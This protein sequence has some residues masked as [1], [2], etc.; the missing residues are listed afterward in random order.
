MV[1]ILRSV[2][3]S[4]TCLLSRCLPPAAILLYTHSIKGKY[5]ASYR[6]HS[7]HSVAFIV[8]RLHCSILT[9]RTVSSSSVP[10]RDKILEKVVRTSSTRMYHRLLLIACVLPRFFRTPSIIVTLYTIWIVST[11]VFYRY[12]FVVSLH[13]VVSGMPKL[14]S[15]FVLP[16]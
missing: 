9:H 11:S 5:K 7:R 13:I 12:L 3:M 1:N 2:D 4:Y 8:P 6:C 16:P 14:P 10:S 15:R